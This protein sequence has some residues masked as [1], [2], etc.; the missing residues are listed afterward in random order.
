MICCF[1][2]SSSDIPVSCLKKVASSGRRLY[3][4]G[5]SS[6]IE[7][8]QTYKSHTSSYEDEGESQYIHVSYFFPKKKNCKSDS[9]AL[10]NY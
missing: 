10:V 5:S 1:N 4:S 2:Y 8:M 7:A 3:K 6:C 9:F